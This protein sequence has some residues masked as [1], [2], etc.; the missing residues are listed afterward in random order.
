LAEGGLKESPFAGDKQWH[1]WDSFSEDKNSLQRMQKPAQIYQTECSRD[2]RHPLSKYHAKHS[3]ISW[4]GSKLATPW[5]SDKIA[6]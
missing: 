4:A 1:P 5:V 3:T 6:P 2:F